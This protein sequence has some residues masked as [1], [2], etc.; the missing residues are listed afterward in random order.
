MNTVFAKTLLW[1][2]G[3]VVLTFTALIITAAISFDPGERRPD[4][5]AH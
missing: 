4:P 3:T 5:W 1:F 2:L